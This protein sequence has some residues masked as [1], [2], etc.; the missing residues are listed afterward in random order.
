MNG[1]GT[2]MNE[3][4]PVSHNHP[5]NT[6]ALAATH[7]DF[8]L[9]TGTE[10]PDLQEQLLVQLS[11]A[12]LLPDS[13]DEE[14]R[15]SR[16]Q[17]ALACLLAIRPSG[18]VEGLLAT[19]MVATHEA[20]M[21]CLR[22]A[23]QDDHNPESRDQNLKHAAKLL[24]VYTRQI[25]AL[26]RHRGKGQQKVTVEHIHVDAGGQAFVGTVEA[27]SRPPP[28]APRPAASHSAPQ[29]NSSNQSAP[30]Q[31]A[32]T[33]NTPEPFHITSNGGKGDGGTIDAFPTGPGKPKRRRKPGR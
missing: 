20:A 3:R 31:R 8:A 30:N 19:Q 9:A 5:P 26:D 33:A 14:Q 25:E 16:L 6:V 4:Q 22:R 1:T 29:Q 15:Q 7:D 2:A 12:L 32:I 23:M 28:P 10:N 13:L 17:S 21:D 27:G 11:N 18:A 24:G